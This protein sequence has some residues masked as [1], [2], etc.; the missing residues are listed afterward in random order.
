MHSHYNVLIIISDVSSGVKID[1]RPKASGIYTGDV[2][3]EVGREPTS[4]VP[5]TKHQ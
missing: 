3:I 2:M 1:N 4:H 5:Q